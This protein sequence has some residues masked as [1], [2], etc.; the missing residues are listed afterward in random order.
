MDESISY[1]NIPKRQPSPDTT[2][3]PSLVIGR[4]YHNPMDLLPASTHGI[5]S[6]FVCT[7]DKGE[8]TIMTD[9]KDCQHAFLWDADCL[10][11]LTGS[12]LSTSAGENIAVNANTP[13]LTNRFVIT[14]TRLNKPTLQTSDDDQRISIK[15][16][17]DYAFTADQMNVRL[18][19]LSLVESQCFLSLENGQRHNLLNTD[20]QEVLFLTADAQSNAI[21]PII[22]ATKSNT[23][24]NDNWQIDITHAIR[25]QLDGIPVE[26]LTVLE[27][28]QTFFMQRELPFTDDN[29]WTPVS[30]PIS[31]GWSMRIAR[32]YDGE[33]GIARQKLLMPSAGHNGMEMPSWK[34]NT[35]TIL[36]S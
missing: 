23:T 5:C 2:P 10:P 27:Q 36:E 25:N 9:N 16:E 22:D 4:K 13:A 14:N 34:N 32:R 29:I 17:F 28:Y 21:S 20:E 26:S 35:L 8:A 31:W 18:G 19:A 1:L 24:L 12:T 33:W 6:D 7:L 3:L 30:S 15:A 11:N